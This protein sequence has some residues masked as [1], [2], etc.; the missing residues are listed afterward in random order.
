MHAPRAPHLET[1]NRILK[2]L[3]STPGKDIWMKNNK[4]NRICGYSDA[5][6]V[7]S[8]DR[9]STIDFCTFIGENLVT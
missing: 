4:S 8:F 6:W 7:G 2:Y 5:D 1:I 3:K 9:K